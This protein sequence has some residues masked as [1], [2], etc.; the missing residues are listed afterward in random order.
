M[1]FTLETTFVQG[2]ML[3]KLRTIKKKLRNYMS[4]KRILGGDKI[5]DNNEEYFYQIMLLIFISSSIF[6]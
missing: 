5:Y 3:W 2:C 1:V 6:T 4:I